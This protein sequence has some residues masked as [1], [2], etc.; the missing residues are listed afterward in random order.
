MA[1]NLIAEGTGTIV[2]TVFENRFGVSQEMNPHGRFYIIEVR[3]NTAI[4]RGVEQLTAH[5]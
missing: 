3:A 2:E 1:L 4:C 5:R